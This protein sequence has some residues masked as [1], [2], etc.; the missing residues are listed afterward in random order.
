MIKKKIKKNPDIDY[1]VTALEAQC[2]SAAYTHTHT[3][4]VRDKE[5]ERERE[6]KKRFE[7]DVVRKTRRLGLY[8]W[9]W[10]HRKHGTDALC[11]ADLLEHLPGVL[12]FLFFSSSSSSPFCLGILLQTFGLAIITP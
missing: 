7:L 4:R 8:K 6:R 1:W 3:T 9:L 2:G 10:K 11:L 5:R 12:L